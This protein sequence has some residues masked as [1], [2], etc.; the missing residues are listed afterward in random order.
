MAKSW[1]LIARMGDWMIHAAATY[2]T[3]KLAVQASE[4]MEYPVAPLDLDLPAE[5]PQ[6]EY[7]EEE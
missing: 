5:I 6:L 3:N 2:A 1:N 4:V 7:A